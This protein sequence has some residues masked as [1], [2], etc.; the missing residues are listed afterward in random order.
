MNE[1]LGNNFKKFAKKK[2]IV[3][4]AIKKLNVSQIKRNARTHKCEYYLVESKF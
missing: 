2:F 4:K 3:V 1:D